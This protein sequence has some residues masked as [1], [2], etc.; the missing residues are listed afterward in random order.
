MS[1][2]HAGLQAIDGGP[3]EEVR[4]A[5]LHLF[6]DEAR[7]HEL[8]GLKVHALGDGRGQNTSKLAGRVLGGAEDL[9]EECVVVAH[10]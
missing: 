3:E 1:R 6:I 5:M 7:G 4:V 10:P 9:L 2:R 8:E